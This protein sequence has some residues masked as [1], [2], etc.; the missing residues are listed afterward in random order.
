MNIMTPTFVT[1]YD[2]SNNDKYTQ[3]K[4]SRTQEIALIRFQIRTTTLNKKKTQEEFSLWKDQGNNL[5]T[6]VTY[7][8]PS[9]NSVVDLKDSD[10]KK[11]HWI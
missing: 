2:H 3:Q 8:I 9:N 5:L 7:S 10:F 11:S 1:D 6:F 4:F